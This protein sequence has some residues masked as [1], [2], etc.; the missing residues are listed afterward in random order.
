MVLLYFLFLPVHVENSSLCIKHREI[1]HIRDTTINNDH[2][3]YMLMVLKKEMK[4]HRFRILYKK[5]KNDTIFS[6]LRPQS[7]AIAPQST[8]VEGSAALVLPSVE[9]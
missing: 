3:S 2:I 6:M 8:P 1:I 4:D 7:P 9:R 5:K